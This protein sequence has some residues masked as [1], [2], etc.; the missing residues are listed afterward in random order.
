MKRRTG[1]LSEGQLDFFRELVNIGAGHAADALQ[2]MLMCPVVL[3]IPGVYFVAPNH[4]AGMLENPASLVIGVRMEMVGD[5]K[6]EIF[7][8]LLAKYRKTIAYM[9]EK[10]LTGTS[11]DEDK[12][13]LSAITEIGNII[14]GV[15]LTAVNKFCGLNIYHTVPY[16][17]TDMKQSLLDETLAVNLQNR[18]VAIMVETRFSV[19]QKKITAELIVVPEDDS[20]KP[21]I[22]AM[23]QAKKIYAAA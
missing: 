2:Q 13:A 23:K 3:K 15:Y 18:R 14:T 10:T 1:L 5:I 19:G 9:A 8:V 12:L 20:V 21:L 22:K 11:Q 4:V 17:A 16:T 6:G 7:F